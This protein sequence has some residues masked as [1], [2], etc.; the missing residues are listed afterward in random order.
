[1]T[2]A[3]VTHSPPSLRKQTAGGLTSFD[4]CCT[5]VTRTLLRLTLKAEAVSDLEAAAGGPS[6]PSGAHRITH[7]A[8][9]FTAHHRII[10]GP[11]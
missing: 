5:P 4:S 7:H 10:A 2:R 6:R 9:G 8:V 1:M 11:S 3:H